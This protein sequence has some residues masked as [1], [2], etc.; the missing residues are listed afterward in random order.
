MGRDD[1]VVVDL[2]GHGD[3]LQQ[4]ALYLP[5]QRMGALR[6]NQVVEKGDFL[7]D[8]HGPLSPQGVVQVPKPLPFPHHLQ[9]GVFQLLFGQFAEMSHLR[10]RYRLIQHSNLHL[11]AHAPKYALE[12]AAKPSVILRIYSLVTWMASGWGYVFAIKPPA[13]VARHSTMRRVRSKACS[14]VKAPVV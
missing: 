10:A 3:L 4:I 12:A 7:H 11:T 5:S 6:L 1:L 2:F 8:H 9:V 13:G 14:R